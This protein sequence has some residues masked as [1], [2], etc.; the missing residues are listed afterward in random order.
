MLNLEFDESQKLKLFPSIY[1]LS[2]M[3]LDIDFQDRSVL[4]YHK[5]LK[6][7][8]K[9]ST[10]IHLMECKTKKKNSFP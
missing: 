9:N 5:E 1:M 2:D 7:H 8:S 4:S 6:M 3:L 10:G